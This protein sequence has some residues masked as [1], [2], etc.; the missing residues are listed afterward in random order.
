MGFSYITADDFSTHGR[1]ARDDETKLKDE[2]DVDSG[3]IFAWLKSKHHF[4]DRP[5]S[6]HK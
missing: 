6:Y 4:G 2:G 5:W 1:P 3:S